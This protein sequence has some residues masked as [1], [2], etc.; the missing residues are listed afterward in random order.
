MNESVRSLLQK[1][2]HI[3]IAVE[4]LAGAVPIYAALTGHPPEHFEDIPK[5]KVKTAFFSVGESNLELLEATDPESPIAKFIAKNGRGGIH[6]VCVAVKDIVAKIAEL[7]AAGIPLVDEVPRQ[8]AHGKLV[9]FVH[10]KGTGG[11]LIELAQ[12]I[13]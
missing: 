13:R 7:K 3:G 11:V 1:I 9:A 8:G 2:D 12:D 10:P 5:E 6:H 4:N